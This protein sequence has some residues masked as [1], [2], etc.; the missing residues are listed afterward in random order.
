MP[1]RIPTSTDDVID[2]RDVIAA[3]EE[4]REERDLDPEAFIEQADLDALEELAEEAEGSPDWQY[5]ETLI[6]ESYF[7]DYARELAEDIGAIQSDAQWPNYCI[8][9]ER[10]ARE[11]QQDYMSVEFNGVTYFIRA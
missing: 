6:R 11:L 5:G 2:S 7:T 4:L 3:I 1:N 8:D 9:W 10:A